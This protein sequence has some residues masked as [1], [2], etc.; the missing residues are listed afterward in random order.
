MF[1]TSATRCA[2]IAVACLATVAL[3]AASAVAAKWS[4]T[5]YTLDSTIR[6]A[7]GDAVLSDGNSSYPYGAADARLIDARSA[8]YF[9][10]SSAN[11]GFTL[12][13][14]GQTWACAGNYASAVRGTGPNGFVNTL[15]A[16]ASQPVAVY[17]TCTVG[18]KKITVDYEDNCALVTHQSGGVSPGGR[19]TLGADATCEAY[20]YAESGKG[21]KTVT[22][23]LYGGGPVA[24][25]FEIAGEVTGT[26][27]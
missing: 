1:P 14:N 16:G 6:D 23:P 11:R 20:V 19:W 21:G 17:I 5:T 12:S 13:V 18:S 4:D 25:P 24:A 3:L 22:T 8:D 27:R 7:A 2:A 26:F 15:A 10:F 9:S